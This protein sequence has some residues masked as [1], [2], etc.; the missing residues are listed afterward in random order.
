[1]PHKPNV[2][3][4]TVRSRAVEENASSGFSDDAGKFVVAPTS[5]PEEY[6]GKGTYENTGHAGGKPTT[7]GGPV[8]KKDAFTA[9]K[10]GK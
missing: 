2:P 4:R 1:M 8:Q 5:I 10:G 3:H 9:R 6:A 7:T